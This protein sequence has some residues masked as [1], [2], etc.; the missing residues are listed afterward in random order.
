L[1][2]RHRPRACESVPFPSKVSPDHRLLK[3][4]STSSR[5]MDLALHRDTRHHTAIVSLSSSISARNRHKAVKPVHL[6]QRHR[7]HTK[8]GKLLEYVYGSDLCVHIQAS[9]KA[10]V[11]RSAS[12]P[13]ITISRQE[14]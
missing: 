4:E 7:P 8:S 2:F 14:L 3:S 10:G 9:I 6:Q 1:P 13:S 5:I 11:E 12:C